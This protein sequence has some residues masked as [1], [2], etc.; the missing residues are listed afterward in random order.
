MTVEMTA[1]ERKARK[2]A[3]DHAY[4]KANI[5]KKRINNSAWAKANPDKVKEAQKTYRKKHAKKIAAYRAAHY[6]EEKVRNAAWQ[7]DHPEAGKAWSA[8]HPEKRRAYVDKWQK[9]HPEAGR[10]GTHNYRSRKKSNGGKLSLG[11]AKRLLVHQKNRCSV[12]KT[13]LKKH[14]YHMDHVVPLFRG[15]KNIDSNIQLTCPKC[16]LEKNSK[17]PIEFMQSRG[18]LL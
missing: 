7:R 16:N 5:E 14:G 6:E 2:Q 12:C 8:A 3:R 11:L 1:E 18:Y 10:I 17:D 4:R 13:S 15:G 9:A